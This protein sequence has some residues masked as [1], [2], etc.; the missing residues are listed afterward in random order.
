MTSNEVNLFAKVQAH[1]KQLHGEISLLSKSKPDNPINTFKLKCINEKLRGANTILTGDFKPFEDFNQ[2][3][4]ES[5]PTNS[6]VVM[7]LS[8][9]LDCLEAWRSAHIVAKGLDWFW[10]LDD[11]QEIWTSQPSRFRKEP[12]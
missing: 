6:D 2:F 8:Q 3:E 4:E 9:Y 12:K 1:V 5:L 10:K 11:H 7:I